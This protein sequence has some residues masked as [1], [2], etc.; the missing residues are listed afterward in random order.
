MDMSV[1]TPATTLIHPAANVV[2]RNPEPVLH[3]SCGVMRVT[4]RMRVPEDPRE[5]VDEDIRIVIPGDDAALHVTHRTADGCHKMVFVRGHHV[6]VIPAN[7]P[8][9][10]YCQ[11]QAEMIVIRLDRSFFEHKAREALGC[12]TAQLVERYA[13]VD[14]FLTAVGRML[15]SEFQ[16]QQIPSTAYLESLAGVIAIHLAKTYGSG[17]AATNVYV[18][19][20]PHKLTRVKA[21]IKEHLAE[22]ISVKQVAAAIHMSPYHFSRM[23]KQATGCSPY[24]YITMQRVERA[25][26]LLRDTKLALVD[27]AAIVGFQTQGHFTHVF[28][29]FT[30]VTPRIFRLNCRGADASRA[31]L[32]ELAA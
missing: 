29:K 2:V 19:L 10:V 31:P 14:P 22:G 27:V 3:A 25:K 20:P 15:R 12:G 4:Y 11:R 17:Q 9:A 18:G 24:L 5:E 28:H 32:K 7:Q 8:H 26:E 6:S 21:Y 13:A 1:L 23:F 30:G 16:M